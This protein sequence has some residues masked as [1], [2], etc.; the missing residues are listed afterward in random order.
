MD[1]ARRRL[2]NSIEYA[3]DIYDTLKDADVLFHVTEWQEFRMPDWTKVVSLMKS[4]LVVDGRGVFK[5]SDLKGLT[6][7][8]IG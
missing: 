5:T 4:P 2:G 1:E 3:S 7:L 8:K 6:Y